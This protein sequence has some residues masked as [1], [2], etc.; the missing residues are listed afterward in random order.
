MIARSPG[1]EPREN[2]EMC[3]YRTSVTGGHF[4]STHPAFAK[5]RGSWVKL[6]DSLEAGDGPGMAEAV[7][8]IQKTTGK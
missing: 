6:F 5:A 3:R 1:V 8:D 7:R 4:V 2:H